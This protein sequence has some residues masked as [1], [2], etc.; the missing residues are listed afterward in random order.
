MRLICTVGVTPAVVT[1]ALDKYFFEERRA[2]REVILLCTSSPRVTESRRRILDEFEGGRRSGDMEI[3]QTRYPCRVPGIKADPAGPV[4]VRCGVFPFNDF[5]HPG[6]HEAL[7]GE[8]A[9]RI[10]Q[11]GDAGLEVEVCLAGGRKTESAVAA[12]AG[13]LFGVRRV[14]HVLPTGL[15]DEEQRSPALH[16]ELSR[17]VL[18]ELP[19]MDFSGVT[20][21]MRDAIGTRISSAEEASEFL[22]ELRVHV[23]NLA[24]LETERLYRPPRDEKDLVT[25][26]R[27]RT[28][29]PKMKEAVER[30]RGY[31]TVG[32]CVLL[33][34]PTGTG[35]GVL[36]Q[37][38]HENGPRKAKPFVIY[39]CAAKPDHLLHSELF[40]AEEGAYTGAERSRAGAVEAAREGTL[41]IDEIDSLSPTAQAALL[42]LVERKEYSRLGESKTRNTKARFIVGT[43][44]DLWTEVRE[45][46]FREDLYYRIASL[47]IRLP[48]L[49]E[50]REDLPLLAEDLLREI[51]AEEG[52]PFRPFRETEV[53]LLEDCCWPGNVRQLRNVLLRWV[54]DGVRSGKWSETELARLVD[55]ARD[56]ANG[57]EDEWERARLKLREVLHRRTTYD[58]VKADL[59]PKDLE[60]FILLARAQYEVEAGPRRSDPDFRE[61]WFRE[62]FGVKSLD[63]DLF[64]ARRRPAP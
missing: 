12:I 37:A 13:Q 30:A 62:H 49:G 55:E 59:P 34:G 32:H 4:D 16:F 18:V 56:R 15:T 45:K 41:F 5:D 58:R 29:N 54:V 7:L 52:V 31:A 60:R 35:K 50:R 38:I 9:F 33:E 40:G 61:N 11:A 48:S 39:Q 2:I 22:R 1:E 63:S 57:A 53:R 19:L 43:N 42:T 8:L 14:V 26:G 44:R 25:F 17:Y 20:R 47:T 23:P 64:R 46:R 10:V 36:A 27:I 6:A 28:R 51:C 24:A 3:L 21:R